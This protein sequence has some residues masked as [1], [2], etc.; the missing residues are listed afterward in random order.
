MRTKRSAVQLIAS[1]YPHP[2]RPQHPRHV[3]FLIGRRSVSRRR[4]PSQGGHAART[5][6]CSRR[7]A[8]FASSR[9]SA[10]RSPWPVLSFPK[11]FQQD[12]HAR[13][14]D[15]D[16]HGDARNPW[17]IHPESERRESDYRH[18]ATEGHPLTTGAV[19]DGRLQRIVFELLDMTGFNLHLLGNLPSE[20]GDDLIV[21]FEQRRRRQRCFPAYRDGLDARRGRCLAAG[22]RS[23]RVAFGVRQV[24]LTLARRRLPYPLR[25]RREG[26]RPPRGLS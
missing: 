1:V 18:H 8:A 12:E 10:S 5:A 20:S 9:M 15:E 2:R 26:G 24:L 4:E 13:G 14:S 17:G 19:P 6:S 25:T 16:G 22:L 23:R 3:H 21:P 7:R 11:G